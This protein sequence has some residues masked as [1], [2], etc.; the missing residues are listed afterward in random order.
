MTSIDPSAT[1][2]ANTSTAP[3]N[4]LSATSAHQVVEPP[5]ELRR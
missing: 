2:A 4:S 1:S 5:L 3:V